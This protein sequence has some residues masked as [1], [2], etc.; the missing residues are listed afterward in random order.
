[1]IRSLLVLASLCCLMIQLNAQ[2]PRER[3][4]AAN[5][6]F[7]SRQY[8]SAA[9]MYEALREEGFSSAVLYYNLGNSYYRLGE[10]APAILNYERALLLRPHDS[11]TRHNLEVARAQLQDDLEVLPDFFLLRWWRGLAFAFSATAWSVVGLLFLWLGIGGLV[12]WIFAGERRQKVR[13][14]VAGIVLL[15]LCIL[16]LTLA[17]SRINMQQH[18]RTA[19]LMTPEMALRSAPDAESTEVLIIHEGLKV[20]LLDQIS[21]WYK[22]RLQNGEEGWLPQAAVEEI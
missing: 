1:M 2:T 4:R 18:S 5:D 16:P 6:A 15:V 20:D 22:V 12:T 10:L 13:G 3:M 8:Q 17:L 9:E 19:I 21:D 14:F 7:Q 11:D